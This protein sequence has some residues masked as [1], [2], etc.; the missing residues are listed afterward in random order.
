L[1]SHS[2][3]LYLFHIV[4]LGIMVDLMPREAMTVGLKLPMLAVFFA[5]SVILAWG[6][7]RFFGDP[8]NRLLRRRF[9]RSGANVR[10]TTEALAADGVQSNEYTR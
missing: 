8:L 4:V 7:A 5:L 1:G 2:Y 6:A 10:D 9:T 3:E